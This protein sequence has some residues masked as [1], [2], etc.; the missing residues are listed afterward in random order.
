MG[1][2]AGVEGTV[3]L[4]L[5]FLKARPVEEGGRRYVFC[6]ASN[7]NW[8]QQKERILK[9]A[10][11]GSKELFLRQGNIDI[12]HMTVLGWALKV[13]NPHSYEIG[14]PLEVRESP[15]GVFVKGEIYRGQEKADWWWRTQTEQSPAM[16][17]FPSVYGHSS[18]DD[19]RKVFDAASGTHRDVIVRARWKGL[20]FAK[21]PQNLSVPGVSVQPFGA[22]AKA[23][24]AALDGPT[25]VGDHC[26]CVRK[27]V[28]GAS[29]ATDSTALSGGAALRGQS[30]DRY[31]HD[32]SHAAGAAERWVEAMAEQ[33]CAHAAPPITRQ[34]I[35]DHF[36]DCEHMTPA[37]ARVLAQRLLERTT[38]QLKAAA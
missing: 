7:E 28:E 27:A 19:K 36:T 22:F 4:S 37:A 13:P 38:Q 29:Y 20:A 3:L 34:K 12:D 21:T 16:R 31:V 2:A 25:C 9:S 35:V 15:G 10:L 14:L 17:W 32:T 26:D 24:I 33:R 30:L 1:G 18:E 23:A 11:L 6:E 5:D 8:D